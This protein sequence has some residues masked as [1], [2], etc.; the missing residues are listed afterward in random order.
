MRSLLFRL[1]M[2]MTLLLA[3][4]PLFADPVPAAAQ[5]QCGTA[6]APRLTTGQMARVTVTDGTGNNLRSQA[7]TADPNNVMGVM[8]DGEVFNVL[9]GPQ[10]AEGYWWYEVRRWDG[11]TGW[12]A[13]GVSGQY[14]IEPWPYAGAQ[15]TTGPK[16][17][18]E[19]G[20]IAYYSG[21][22][23]AMAPYA[24]AADGTSPRA[25]GGGV[26]HD[27]ILAWSPDGTYVAYSD[28]VD[29]WVI[30]LFDA[31]QVTNTPGFN[32]FQPTWSPDG[33]RIAFVSNRDGNLEIYSARMDGG[34]LRRLTNN[35][36][37]DSDPAWSPDGT[38]I[39]FTSD[40]SGNTE[41]YVM[42]A[43][44]G[45]NPTPVTVSPGTEAQ[46]SWS[47]DGQ[48]LAYV[49]F[50]QN[51]PAA[52][53]VAKPG[54]APVQVTQNMVVMD[55]V[56]SPDSQ[57]LA[58]VGES[59]A[60]SGQHE[61]FS[62]RADGTDLMQ[63][64]VHGGHAA[65]VSWSPDGDWIAY[66]KGQ[67]GNHDIYT[68][69]SNGIGVANLTNSAGIDDTY[70]TFPPVQAPPG[71]QPGQPAAAQT[72]APAAP[73]VN[74]AAQDLQL[75]YDPG[76]PVF[77][78]KNVSGQYINLTLLSFVGANITV[79]AT[80]WESYTSSP[81]T[82]FMPGGCL[83][84]WRFGLPEQPSPAECGAARQGWLTDQVSMFWTGPT[85][86]VVYNGAVVATCNS[87]AAGQCLVDLP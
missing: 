54:F 52:I 55:P 76:V 71:T 44:D 23:T 39:A 59:P 53:Y 69:R 43:A 16:P 87:A 33:Q 57:R 6:P 78:L 65:G 27:N 30:G 46:V 84:I 41:L 50:E 62:V 17:K 7:S 58:F 61:I 45:A 81:L 38:R 18:L 11:Q 37:N 5:G 60:G 67:V 56:W 28:G 20:E 51:M 34:D 63:Y 14:W 10:C 48:Q 75:I 12:T 42:S 66:A 77:T 22:Q 83:M 25:L 40:R 26:A 21:N 85:F 70:P 31:L 73:P 1:T 8:G 86:Q 29:I 80:V 74:P 15:L 9:S 72:P 47:P 3:W 49:L 2:V 79:P 13:E 32:N 19:N 64:T 82:S 35:P 36:G 68:I 24:M 4:V